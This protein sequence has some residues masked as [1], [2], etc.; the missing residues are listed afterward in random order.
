MHSHIP[1]GGAAIEA[2]EDA[3]GGRRPGG[4]GVG[5]V[6]ADGVGGKVFEFTELGV[7]VGGGYAALAAAGGGDGAVGADVSGHLG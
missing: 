2:E 1:V 5:A 3:V 7:F 4:T 6:E